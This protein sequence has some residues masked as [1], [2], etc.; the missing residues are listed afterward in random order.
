VVSVIGGLGFAT[1][2]EKVLWQSETRADPDR[3]LA[4]CTDLI[5]AKLASSLKTLAEGAYSGRAW[6]LIVPAQNPLV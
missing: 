2:T 6:F 4:F 3:R 1:E 5:S